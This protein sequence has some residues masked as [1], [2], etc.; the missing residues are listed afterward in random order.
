MHHDMET[1]TDIMDRM[2]SLVDGIFAGDSDRIP[3]E[4]MG[5]SA[6]I[7]KNVIRFSRERMESAGI[8]FIIHKSCTVHCKSK[9]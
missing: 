3:Y 1:G 9:K 7:A 5:H 8:L 6:L 4:F 2:L